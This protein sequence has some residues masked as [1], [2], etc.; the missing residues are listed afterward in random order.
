MKRISVV[1]AVVVMASCNRQGAPLNTVRQAPAPQIWDRVQQCAAQ[2]EV[3]RKHPEWTDDNI[4]GV[5]VIAWENHYNRAKEQCFV[6]V[7]LMNTSNTKGAD[8]FPLTTYTISDGFENR[9]LLSCSD[10]ATGNGFGMCSIAGATDETVTEC[11]V[12]QKL[13]AEL[14]TN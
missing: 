8:R 10:T 9:L 1:L 11:N 12:C 13:A 7:T 4:I 2:A 6:K 5:K 14:M 3:L